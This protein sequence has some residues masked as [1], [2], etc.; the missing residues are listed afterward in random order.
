MIFSSNFILPNREFCTKNS[1]EYRRHCSASSEKELIFKYYLENRK[2]DVIIISTTSSHD[3]KNASHLERSVS[4]VLLYYEE[5]KSLMYALK[6]NIVMWI[7]TVFQ[8]HQPYMNGQI[9]AFNKALFSL[10]ESELT[11]AVRSPLTIIGF[12]NTAISEP[13]SCIKWSS[14]TRHYHPVFYMEA[15]V[16]LIN[17]FCSSPVENI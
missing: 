3:F 16:Q 17:L 11:G 5:L 6:P 7:T 8:R 14:D 2:P 4:E 12:D 9:K 1:T 15:M 13:L 10:L